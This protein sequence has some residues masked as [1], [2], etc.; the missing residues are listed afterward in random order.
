MRHENLSSFLSSKELLRLHNA[1]EG[2]TKERRKT[3]LHYV[4]FVFNH[5]S[6]GWLT[7]HRTHTHTR[8]NI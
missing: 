7:N 2:A 1:N 4:W 6:V 3:I 8:I 5:R